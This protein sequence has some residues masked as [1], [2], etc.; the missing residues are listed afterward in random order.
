M[1]KLVPGFMRFVTRPWYGVVLRIVGAC[2][3]VVGLIAAGLDASW[4]GFTPLVWLLLALA[5]FLGVICN[6]LAQIIS[7][8][9][10]RDQAEAIEVTRAAVEPP[11]PV[12]P[13]PVKPVTPEAARVPEPARF[14]IEAYCVKCR[15]KRL[16]GDPKRLMLANGRPAYQGSCPVCG[17]KVTRIIRIE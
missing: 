10:T 4:A 2:L 8:Q 3:L 14:E 6:E 12:A 1:Q 9:T 17:T 15:D 11:S 16:I 13:A 5:A 7:H